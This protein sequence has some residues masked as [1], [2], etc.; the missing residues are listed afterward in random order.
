[1][2]FHPKPI[3]R[4]CY[5]Y[6]FVALYILF[7]I[8]IMF[9]MTFNI[10]MTK[11]EDRLTC[12]LVGAVL[13]IF[14]STLTHIAFWEKFFATLEITEDKIIWKCPFRKTQ[15]MSLDDCVVI[16]ACREH[17]KNGI[18]SECIYISDIAMPTID[19]DLRGGLKRSRHLI[20]YVYSDK[21]CDYL[22]R[23]VPDKRTRTL[24]AYRWRR[25][26]RETGMF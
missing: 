23:K 25:K 3:I 4:Y 10:A 6:V 2:K 20:K 15:S 12:F 16:G 17:V 8:Y 1:M 26:N 18:R 5:R 9:G 13:L 24:G 14:G 21:L 19:T 7:P 22:I 11:M